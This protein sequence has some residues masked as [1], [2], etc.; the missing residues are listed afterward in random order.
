MDKAIRNT[1]RNAVT[2][3]RHLLEGA[4]TEVLQGQFGIHRNGLI[5]PATS[6]THLSQAD[7]AYRQQICSHL[8]H[9][10]MGDSK[11]SEAL[12]QLI[13]EVAFTHLN[14]LCA[15]KLLEKRGLLRETVSRGLNSNGFKFYL[16]EHPED[17]ALWSS[18]QQDLAYRHFLE[19]VGAALSEEI[20]VLFS[21]TDPANCL[22]PP[23]RVLELVLKE[24][25]SPDLTEIWESDETIGWIYQYFTPK[26]LRDQMRKES[27]A[28][29][30]G[31][32]LAV[33]N[34]FYTPRY[35][36]EFLVENTLARLWYEMRRGETKLAKCRYLIRR[37][38][39]IWLSPDEMPPE[40][41]PPEAEIIPYRPPKDPRELRI[42]DP[43]C[44]SG[45][46][47]LYCFDLLLTIYEEAWDD[48]KLGPKIRQ[49]YAGDL[50]AYRAAIPGLILRHNLHGVDIDL[51]AT[52]IAALALWL[53]A[54]RAYK[55]LGF[56]HTG[57]PII[58]RSNIVLAEPMPGEYDLLRDYLRT[59]DPPALAPL[60]EKVWE[61][62]KLAGD[63]GSLLKVEKAMEEAIKIAK[64]D[65]LH[66]KS[67]V[68]QRPLFEEDQL[69]EQGTLNF[70]GI[71]DV[72]FFEQEAKPR[73]LEALQRFAEA[74]TNG[75]GYTR[76]IFAEDAER[77]FALVEILEK[78]YD[79]VLMNPAF[80][81]A[82]TKAKEYLGKTY[83]NTKN[84]IFAVFVERGLRLLQPGGKLGAITSRTGFFLTSFKLWREKLLLNEFRPVALADLGAGVLD[85]AMVETAAYVLEP[86]DKGHQLA[87]LQRPQW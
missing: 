87:P 49:Q 39:P 8:E 46:F 62:M 54:Q 17:E 36:V 43:A 14:R 22:F 5:E 75:K 51:R 35:V 48:T 20:G 44:G 71:S 9:L 25:N 52:Q 31:Y 34:Q 63:A 13:R 21:P 83:P 53:R 55:E 3:C 24:I 29:R 19:S 81:E 4:I 18:G 85:T 33:R 72:V 38:Q 86:R 32:E 30:N 70:S 57:R 78:R 68:E 84:D 23:Q 80:G 58:R 2:E 10:Q 56:R 41:A 76:R 82:S 42:L 27:Q 37:H 59:L 12:S 1:L 6:M 47:L 61:E 50:A 45:H 65:Y 26:E 40:S 69:P 64:R 67:R 28:P 16:V 73:A 66:S 74:A 11:L 15:Y 79:V 60:V 77:G 7:R